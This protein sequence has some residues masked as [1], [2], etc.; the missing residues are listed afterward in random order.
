MESSHGLKAASNHPEIEEKVPRARWGQRV[1]NSG[2]ITEKMLYW[3][4]E[5]ENPQA[6]PDHLPQTYNHTECLHVRLTNYRAGDELCPTGAL[7]THTGKH[8]FTL[9]KCEIRQLS[10]LTS[11]SP[12]GRGAGYATKGAHYHQHPNLILVFSLFRRRMGVTS[13]SPLT[14]SFWCCRKENGY[15]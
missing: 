1:C 2:R 5:T 13:K 15:P 14:P 4:S 12:A 10:W 3:L 9:P 7:A 8:C 6:D 11:R